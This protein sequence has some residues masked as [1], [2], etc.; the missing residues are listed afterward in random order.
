MLNILIY[1]IFYINFNY[2]SG[3]LGRKTDMPMLFLLE[4]TYFEIEVSIITFCAFDEACNRFLLKAIPM[5]E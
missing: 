3:F 1:I 2:D 4:F 5:C